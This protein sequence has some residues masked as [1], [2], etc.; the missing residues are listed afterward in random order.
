MNSVEIAPSNTRGEEIA[1]SLTHGLGTGLAIAA[2]V[3]L[4]A[5][6]ALAHDGYKLATEI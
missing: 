2:L 4:V 6:A 1:N 5:F 3:I